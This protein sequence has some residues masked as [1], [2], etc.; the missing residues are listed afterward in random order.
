VGE[1]HQPLQLLPADDFVG[2]ED[3]LDPA[4]DHRLGLADLLAAD[5]DGA[6]LD[7]FQS[8]DRAFMGLGVRP[9]SDAAARDPFR[10]A[11]QIALERVE[12]DDQ[13][14]GVDLVEGHADFGGGAGSHRGIS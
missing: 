6:E 9:H 7:L 13:G 14:R 12:I 5:A 1:R 3:V 10:Q 11:A 2:D 8:D 4:L